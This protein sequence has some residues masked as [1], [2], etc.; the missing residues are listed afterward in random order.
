MGLALK[1]SLICVEAESA[2]AEKRTAVLGPALMAWQ[3][4]LRRNQ[5]LKAHPVF[6]PTVATLERQAK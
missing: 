4:A 6:Q 5:N 2:P 3:E 1:A